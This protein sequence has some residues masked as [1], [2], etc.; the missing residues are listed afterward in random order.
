MVTLAARRARLTRFT[1]APG[2]VALGSGGACIRWYNE[3]QI[4]SSEIRQLGGPERAVIGC[5]GKAQTAAI[6]PA[7]ARICN[8]ASAAEGGSIGCVAQSPGR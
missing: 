2:G 1:G 3:A 8:A 4:K 5:D 6:A 7:I